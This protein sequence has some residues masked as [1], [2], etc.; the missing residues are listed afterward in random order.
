MMRVM[1]KAK[2]RS[3]RKIER[4]LEKRRRKSLANRRN[5]RKKLITSLTNSSILRIL[6]PYW[7]NTNSKKH[8]QLNQWSSNRVKPFR[9]GWENMLFHLRK[10]MMLHPSKTKSGIQL[11]TTKKHNKS[12]I[13]SMKTHQSNSNKRIHVNKMSKMIYSNNFRCTNSGKRLLAIKSNRCN[14]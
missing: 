13:H 1:K 8:K 12:K 14:K 5:K 9:V 7:T 2:R 4:V 3:L 10:K 11:S 6:T